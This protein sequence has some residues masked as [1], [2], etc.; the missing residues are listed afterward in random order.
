MGFVKITPL[1]IRFKL[2][3]IA[4][5]IGKY[6]GKGY[7]YEALDVRKS[8]TASQIKQIYKLNTKRLDIV[9]RK[10]GKEKADALKCT[11]RKVFEC[12]SGRDGIVRNL[13]L[14]FD[15]QWHFVGV[16]GEPF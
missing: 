5:Y 4:N 8:F 15:S 6:I 16:V 14:E 1:K 9:M 12:V 10:Y 7:E 13:L 3:R 2:N 11:Y